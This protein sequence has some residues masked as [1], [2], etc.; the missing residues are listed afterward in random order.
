MLP[1]AATCVTTRLLLHVSF[2][3]LFVSTE[4]ID[5]YSQY[6]TKSID[7][8]FKLNNVCNFNQFQRC[9]AGIKLEIATYVLIR[10]ITFISARVWYNSIQEIASLRM[11]EN[12]LRTKHSIIILPPPEVEKFTHVQT[13]NFAVSVIV[14]NF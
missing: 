6:R 3:S 2:C 12:M 14:N 7:T 9:S 5:I 4:S 13:R 11:N 1:L 10:Q 8:Y